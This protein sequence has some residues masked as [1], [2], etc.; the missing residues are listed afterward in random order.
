[1]E[2]NN[3]IIL[4]GM[5][6]SGK[7]TVGV[8]LAK[9]I[10]FDFIDTD[11]LIQRQEKAK[12]DEIITSKGIERFL[13]IESSVCGSLDISHAVI[14]TGGSAIYRDNAMH[15][16]SSL[17]QIVYLKVDIQ[18]L[19]VR[20]SDMKQ[21]GVV[22]KGGQTLEELIK[23]RTGLYEQYADIV[24]DENGLNLEQTV[25]QIRNKLGFIK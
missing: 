15:H 17:G 11:I 13:D 7:S 5:P 19:E 9:L 12:L 14:A 21:R 25:E 6:A 22:L 4:I 3:N 1:M 18:D 8:I 16:L 20:L 10:G 2:R 23:E 24:I